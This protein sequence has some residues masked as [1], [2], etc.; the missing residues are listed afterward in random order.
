MSRI[1]EFFAVLA[2]V[3]IVDVIWTALV[4]KVSERKAVIAGLLSAAFAVLSGLITIAFVSK[5]WLLVAA[6]IASFAGTYYCIWRE[7]KPTLQSVTNGFWEWL[8]PMDLPR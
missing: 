1:L 7:E 4:I 5:P 8:D 2:G 6:G 3:F